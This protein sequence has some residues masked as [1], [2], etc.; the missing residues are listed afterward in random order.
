M[1]AR[2]F[3]RN[4]HVKKNPDH[5]LRWRFLANGAI[6]TLGSRNLDEKFDKLLIKFSQLFRIE[7]QSK[8][9]CALYCILIGGGVV[10]THVP[11]AL[12]AVRRFHS[13]IS[14]YKLICLDLNLS[15]T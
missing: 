10:Q 8:K 1:N 2:F 3:L 4:A 15:C 12:L 13:L 7:R 9:V 5:V 11:D 14:A 6:A